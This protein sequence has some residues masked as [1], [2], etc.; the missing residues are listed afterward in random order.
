MLLHVLCYG[1]CISRK[2]Q[3]ALI[4]N[5]MAISPNVTFITRSR[6]SVVALR[7]VTPGQKSRYNISV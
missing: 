3:H 6:R 4:V 1:K 2:T 7:R 5:S